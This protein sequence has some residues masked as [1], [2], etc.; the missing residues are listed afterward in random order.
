MISIVDSHCHLNF[1]S[2]YSD[3]EGALERANNV[4]VR[5]FLTVCTKF[6]EIDELIDISKK[7]DNI[8]YSVGIHPEYAGEHLGK[9]DI[10]ETLR[11]YPN[12]IAIGEAGVDKHIN[13]PDLD[14]QIACFEKQLEACH[15]LKKP[16]IVHSREADEETYNSISKYSGKVIGVLHC[17][18]GSMYFAK[19]ALDL[20]FYISFSGILTYKKND[21]LREIA[22]YVPMDKVLIET[23]SPFLS[24]QKYRGKICEP[25]FIIE[26]GDML[27]SIKSISIEELYKN[28]NDNF[29]KLFTVRC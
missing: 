8:Y 10:I 2:I 20:G 23:D 16:I 27:A 26:T 24:P 1:D 11:K 18:N 5:R 17:F 19:K 29:N 9:Y 21:T 3:I 12:A 25:S 15:L 4:S 6:S 14:I 22:K 7:F 13:G 28:I